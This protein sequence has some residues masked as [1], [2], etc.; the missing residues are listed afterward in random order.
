MISEP[1]LI[2]DDCIVVTDDGPLP[3]GLLV[4]WPHGVVMPPW[5]ATIKSERGQATL[6]DLGALY[7]VYPT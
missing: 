6:K 7:G 3:K 4:G 1:M 2:I 5:L